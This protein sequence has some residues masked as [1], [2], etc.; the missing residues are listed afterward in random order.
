MSYNRTG[1]W[2]PSPVRTATGPGRNDI[3]QS[4]AV[5]AAMAKID[6]AFGR[7]QEAAR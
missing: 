2:T 3:L 6:R 1:Q 7:P 4:P 5:I